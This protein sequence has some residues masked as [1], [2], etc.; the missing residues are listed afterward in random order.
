MTVT[1]VSLN[2][3]ANGYAILLNDKEGK[4]FIVV[5]TK[6]YVEKVIV[7]MLQKLNPAYESKGPEQDVRSME[8]LM[9][10]VGYKDRTPHI[11]EIVDALYDYKE[12]ADEDRAYV[13]MKKRYNLHFGGTQLVPFYPEFI[14]SPLLPLLTSPI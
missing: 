13:E 12:N 8:K 5:L 3:Q 10:S 6:K 14:P 11:I 7:P 1:V 9:K 2:P 4:Q